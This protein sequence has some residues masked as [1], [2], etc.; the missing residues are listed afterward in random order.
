[1]NL[2]SRLWNRTAPP[3]ATRRFDGA[4]GGR[5]GW[6]M[7]S[8]GRINPEVAGA[9]ASLRSRA[10]YLAA[11]N[12]WLSQAV[13]NWTG[14]LI[15]PGIVPTSKHPDAATRR[16]C[17]VYFSTWAERA[18]AEG[19]TDFGGLQAIIADSMVKAGEAVVLLVDTEDGPRLRVLPKC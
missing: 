3:A 16:A 6:G 17:N 15:G 9:G 1:M 4:A 14:A 5:R 2:L 10:A 8:F 12:P 13:S 7:G 11:N 18:D 19:R